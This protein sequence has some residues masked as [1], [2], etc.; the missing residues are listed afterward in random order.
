MQGVPPTKGKIAK[1]TVEVAGGKIFVEEAEETMHN[2]NERNHNKGN[3]DPP[4]CYNC[5]KRGHIEKDCWY[6]NKSSTV[7]QCS[8]CNKSGHEEKDCWHKNKN[9]ANFHEEKTNDEVEENLFLLCLSANAEFVGDIWFLDS[10]CSHH[11]TGDKILF[12]EMMDVS[13][14]S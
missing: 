9:Q 13:V 7:P 8:I 1:V 12:V 10:G 5:K 11:M 14:R 2:G 4:Q 3:L 6:K